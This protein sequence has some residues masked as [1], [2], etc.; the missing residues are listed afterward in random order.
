MIQDKRDEREMDQIPMS[1]KQGTEWGIPNT[2][3]Y[4]WKN[5]RGRMTNGNVCKYLKVHDLRRVST[6][7]GVAGKTE[8]GEL[9]PKQSPRGD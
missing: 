2:D 8:G 1:H 7:S 5:T 9:D 3:D 4:C 6:S